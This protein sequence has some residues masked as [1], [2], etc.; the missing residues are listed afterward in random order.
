MCEI[1]ARIV[2]TK[3]SLIIGWQCATESY[4]NI[5]ANI[6]TKFGGTRRLATLLGKPPS[7]VQSWKKAGNIP[8]CHQLLVLE[9]AKTNGIQLSPA[10]FFCA[11]SNKKREAA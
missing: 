9:T 11:P 3:K 6:I 2:C 4:M 1:V 10:D 5:A 7:T 8:A